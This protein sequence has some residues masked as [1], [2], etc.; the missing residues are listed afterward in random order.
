MLGV[1][2]RW[3]L[4]NSQLFKVIAP[5]FIDAELRIRIR[6]NRMCLYLTDPDPVVRRTDPALAPDASIIKQ[7][8]L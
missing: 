8:K 2:P 6:K 7:E 1:L 5:G 4:Y 3:P